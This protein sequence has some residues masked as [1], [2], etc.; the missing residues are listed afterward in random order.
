MGIN[1][2]ILP[3]LSLC[4]GSVLGGGALLAKNALKQGI[5]VGVPAKMREV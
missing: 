4:E 3:N 2:A 5:Y 1:S